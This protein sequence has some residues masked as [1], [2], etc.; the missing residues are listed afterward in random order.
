VVV[1]NRPEHG[2]VDL[3]AL[4][5]LGDTEWPVSDLTRETLIVRIRERLEQGFSL[6]SKGY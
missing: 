1:T 2:L 4:S 3:D 6:W 5:H